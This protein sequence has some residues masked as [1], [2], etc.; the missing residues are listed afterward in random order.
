MELVESRWGF[1]EVD[2]M[3]DAARLDHDGTYV[4]TGTYD[5][6]ELVRMVAA[7]SRSVGV[8]VPDLVRAF[9][10]HLFTEFVERYAMF[11]ADVSDCRSFLERVHDVIHIDVRKLH[12]DAELP[13]LR[14]ERHADGSLDVHSRPR[15]HFADLAEGLIIGCIRHFGEPLDVDRDDREVAEGSHVVFR[16]RPRLAA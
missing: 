8:P 7:L 11:F 13:S 9:G 1:D 5:H 6:A 3:I 10:E 14:C 2:R 12:P 4:A 16:V 15:R